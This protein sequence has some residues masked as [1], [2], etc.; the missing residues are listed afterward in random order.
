MHAKCGHRLNPADKS[1]AAING[2]PWCVLTVRA[3]RDRCD[4]CGRMTDPHGA[5]IPFWEGP[6][7]PGPQTQM[8][9]AASRDAAFES[10][11]PASLA[12]LPIL[13]QHLPQD[14]ERMG[15]TLFKPSVRPTRRRIRISTAR[16]GTSPRHSRTRP[17]PLALLVACTVRSRGGGTASD[18]DS[19]PRGVQR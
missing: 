7:S 13:V 5:A 14:R 10:P 9:V 16:P 12:M 1:I 15:L 17:D 3:G 2:C 18:L 4:A 11:H 8:S 19:I 6:S